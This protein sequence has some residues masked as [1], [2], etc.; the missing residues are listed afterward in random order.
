MI[1]IYSEL[2]IEGDRKP[3][4]I[5]FHCVILN[6]LALMRAV[7]HLAHR[8]I[9][10]S[11]GNFL[12]FTFAIL[13]RLLSCVGKLLKTKLWNDMKASRRTVYLT[14]YYIL[15]ICREAALK[16]CLAVG[17]YFAT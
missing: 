11:N 7:D 13:Q 10:V 17:K 9:N 1:Y 2:K 16:L 6:A 4:C 12:K 14:Y 3:P 8:K 15:L 5:P